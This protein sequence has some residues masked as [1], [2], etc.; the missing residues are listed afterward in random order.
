MAGNGPKAAGDAPC[1]ALG[2]AAHNAAQ[3]ATDSLPAMTVQISIARAANVA[4]S[5]E[6]SVQHYTMTQVTLPDVGNVTC[7][8]M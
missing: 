6:V 1:V 2:I 4:I 7:A 5:Y 8:T 3:N